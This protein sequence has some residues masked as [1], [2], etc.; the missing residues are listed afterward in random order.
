MRHQYFLEARTK[1]LATS[2]ECGS[3]SSKVRSFDVLKEMYQ[4]R[5]P[6]ISPSSRDRACCAAACKEIVT[7]AAAHLSVSTMC[8]VAVAC[9]AIAIRRG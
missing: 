4:G 5:F 8:K 9:H 3:C 7:A 1:S 6:Q 2:V